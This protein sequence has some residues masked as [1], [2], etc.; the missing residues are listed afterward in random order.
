VT[1][2]PREPGLPCIRCGD[3]LPACP[4]GL[5]A[6]D[7]WLALLA[8]DDAEA[9]RLGLADCRGCAAC[10]AVCPSRLPL[11][12][13]LTARRDALAAR[14]RLL[15]QAGPARARY[16][17]RQQRLQREAAERE[18]RERQLLQ[19]ATSEDAVEAA[20]ARAMARRRPPDPQ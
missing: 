7:L 13:Q 17:A 19:Q 15:R 12:A 20:I 8:D 6:Q 14:E 18:A 16:Q 4:E 5:Q 3:C 2:D 10:D 11:A 1:P 9:L